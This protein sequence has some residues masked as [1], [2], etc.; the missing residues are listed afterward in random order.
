MCGKKF[1]SLVCRPIGAQFMEADVI[2]L[3]E[4]VMSDQGVAV[5]QEKHYKLVPPDQLSPEE[6]LSYANSGG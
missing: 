2:A 6:L 3:F 4:F 5:S 1:P